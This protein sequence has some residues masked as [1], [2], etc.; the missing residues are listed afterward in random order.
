[1][2]M[3]TEEQITMAIEKIKLDPRM[4]AKPATVDINA[5]LALIQCAIESQLTALQWVLHD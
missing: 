3:K 1:M 4:K 5:P 2:P